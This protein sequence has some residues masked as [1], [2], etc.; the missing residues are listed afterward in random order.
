M[1]RK[2]AY[3]V[4][5]DDDDAP[6]DSGSSSNASDA[7]EH[8]TRRR[9]SRPTRFHMSSVK[10]ASAHLSSHAAHPGNHP[11]LS[12]LSRTIVI[13]SIATL[14]CV[15]TGL[16]YTFATPITGLFF[17]Q[18]SLFVLATILSFSSLFITAQRAHHGTSQSL[19][20]G[21]AVATSVW[22]L[23]GVVFA[24]MGIVECEGMATEERV[25]VA[26]CIANNPSA[27][28]IATK[29]TSD[30]FTAGRGTV[31]VCPQVYYDSMST[32]YALFATWLGVFFVAL[33]TLLASTFAHMRLIGHLSLHFIGQ[34][35]RESV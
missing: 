32:F 12:C 35:I 20:F 13:S 17:G 3:A 19:I 6:R 8:S 31:S 16:G 7:S 10:R 9:S 14:V 2:G 24:S 4:Q 18:S 21:I 11:R 28:D 1:P 25:F 33:G 30:T 23:L 5:V 34:L 22:L 26:Q 29:C 27:P 15:A